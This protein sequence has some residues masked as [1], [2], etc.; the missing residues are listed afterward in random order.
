MRAAA[1]SIASGNPSRRRQ[2]ARIV[3]ALLSLRQK[4]GATSR[5]RAT[6]N[7][8][9]GPEVGT[10]V[11][12]RWHG[13]RDDSL[14]PFPCQSER[15]AAGGQDTQPRAMTQKVGNQWRR[16]H[17]VFAVVQHQEQLAVAQSADQG[18][19]Q[20]TRATVR[21]AERRGQRRRHERWIPYRRQF[22]EG[23][24]VGKGG[25]APGCY[26]ERESCLSDPSWAGQR[27]QPETIFDQQA[28]DRRDIGLAADQ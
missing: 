9:A 8:T 7:V 11:S 24:T 28:A 17:H 10:G 2:I 3:A 1:N 4:S 13:E 12:L 6:N 19:A 14:E 22:D 18:L 23:N 26:T 5:A 27:D 21:H 15:G 25:L 16:R 20:W